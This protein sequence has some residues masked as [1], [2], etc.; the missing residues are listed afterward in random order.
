MKRRFTDVEA[1]Q[2]ADDEYFYRPLVA[3][4]ELFTYVAHV[5]AG[6]VM[7]PDAEE[8]KLFELSLFMVEG[9]LQAECGEE[10]VALSVGDALH[11]PRGTP[12]GVANRTQSPAT[13]VL[14][15]SP[16]PPNINLDSLKQEAIDKGRVVIDAPDV[17]GR[18]GD[19]GFPPN[20][21][22]NN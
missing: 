9:S 22:T 13:F 12:F 1:Y 3:G 6:G 14:S 15:F 10:E 11:I 5:P 4:E 21:S 18:V 16:P 17:M 2:H 20:V 19:V 7:P 8:A